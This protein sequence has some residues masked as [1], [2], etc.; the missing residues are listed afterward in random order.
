MDSS[1]SS[2]VLLTEDPLSS[3]PKKDTYAW[4][5]EMTLALIRLYKSHEYLFKKVN[6]KKKSVW[7][8]ICNRIK[9]MGVL[10][11]Y[12]RQTVRESGNH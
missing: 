8:L 7:E 10:K 6:I 12:S 4:P 3:F 1:L 5:K 11:N 9:Q 2:V